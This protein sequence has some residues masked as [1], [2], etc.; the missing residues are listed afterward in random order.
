MRICKKHFLYQ[1]WKLCDF[2]TFNCGQ[3]RTN[4]SWSCGQ[5]K[6]KSLFDWLF[7]LTATF[8]IS[9]TTFL[10]VVLMR[11]WA[12]SQNNVS[13]CHQSQ[14]TNID[15]WQSFLFD[16]YLTTRNLFMSSSCTLSW[17]VILGW[18]RKILNQEKVCLPKYHNKLSSQNNVQKH[19]KVY[20][21][22]DIL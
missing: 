8:V 4:K 17:D 18:Y 16:F 9:R 14:I 13:K 5:M 10:L 6:R 15:S 12:I 20:D 19:E 3:N 11:K 7:Y 21:L 1:N 22:F 2:M